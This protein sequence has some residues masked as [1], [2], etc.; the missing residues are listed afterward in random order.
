MSGFSC[1]RVVNGQLATS[2]LPEPL[3]PWWS[4][5][6]TVL[7]ATALTLVRD[8][9][10]SLDEVVLG[11]PFTLRQL[12]KHEAGLADYGEL[13]DYHAAVARGDEPWPASEMLERLDAT[14]L[15]YQPGVGWGYSNVGYLY[16]TRLIEQ[17]SGTS[18]GSAIEQ[19]VLQPLGVP[20]VRLARTPAD[21]RGVDM[22]SSA[23]YHPGWVY[24]GLLVGSVSAAALLL[25]R[26]LGGSLLPAELLAQMQERRVLG[27]P[28]AG[29]PWTVAGYAL[30]LMRGDIEGGILL[31][32]HTGV[33]PGSV[34]AVY[35]CT[36][37]AG[38]A[39]CAVFQKDAREGD[40]EA[41][42]V[43]SLGG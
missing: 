1:E 3:V 38:T 36:T 15:R 6:K 13:A 33:G 14:R 18:L 12:L 25:D 26:L 37:D 17:R 27:G 19:R 41:E 4:F 7:A 43:A 42:L 31:T 28:I 39:T 30:G 2:G 35:R 32:G 21:L 40:V 9:L 34:I 16:V 23:A 5:T 8:G 22:G 24:H 10:V 20:E 11:G 29:R